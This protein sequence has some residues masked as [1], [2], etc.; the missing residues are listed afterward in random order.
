MTKIWSMNS[1][2]EASVFQRD[3][4]ERWARGGRARIVPLNMAM[5]TL[6][7][8]L[9]P[10]KWTRGWMRKKFGIPRSCGDDVLVFNSDAVV[11]FRNQ[12][13]RSSRA[14]A[15]DGEFDKMVDDGHRPDDNTN[16]G[17]GVWTS[18][19]TSPSKMPGAPTQKVRSMRIV[20]PR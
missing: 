16:G 8:V 19:P 9:E 6:A 15:D 17:I 18:R 13:Y 5:A 3:K 14:I 7:G 1:P 4:A 10:R 2:F 11:R 20:F 12:A